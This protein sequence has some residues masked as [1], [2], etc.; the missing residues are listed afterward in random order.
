MTTID[1][2][3]RELHARTG[4]YIRKVNEN[5]RIVVTDRGRPVAEIQPLGN[6]GGHGPARKWSERALVP[7]Y[8]KVMKKSIGGTD[9][10][11]MISEERNR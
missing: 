11:Q 6:Q 3:V 4:H 7:E 10:S 5:M 2:P 9:S 8:K 1:I